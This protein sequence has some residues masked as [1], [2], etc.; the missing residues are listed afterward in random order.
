MRTIARE[1]N[2]V[3]VYLRQEGR[4]IGLVNK[5]RAYELQDC[6]ADTVDAN[7]RLG[8]PADAR[9]YH[10]G[11]QILRDLGVSSI[12]IMTNNPDKIGKLSEYGIEV[13][14]RIPIVIEPNED[15]EFYLLTKR[16][17]MHHRPGAESTDQIR[18]S[19]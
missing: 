15:N 13:T 11:A 3:L 17:R 1:R 19:I 8:F 6:G 7:L 9:D 18:K 5:L 16:N 14:E 12:R 4:G 10:V 2:G